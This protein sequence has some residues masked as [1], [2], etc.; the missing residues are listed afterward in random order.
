LRDSAAV[1]DTIAGPAPGDPYTAPAPRRPF[2]EEPGSNPGSL[3]IGLVT[4]SALGDVHGDCVEAAESAARLLEQLGHRVEP[5][6]VPA[7]DR[8]EVGPWIAAGIARD[9]DRWSER[10]GDPIGATDVEPLTWALAEVGRATNGAQYVAQAEA[11]WAWSRE[12][13]QPW[14][15]G[16]DLLL[17]P[18]SA[19]PPP[20]IGWVA[21]TVPFPE[22]LQRMGQQTIFTLPFDVTG[23]PALSLP[24]HWNAAGLP[25]GV[26]LVAATA[27]EDLLFRIGAQLEAAQPWADRRPP[28]HA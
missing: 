14:S 9:L 8:V 21:P 13:Q 1:L 24:L 3:R 6:R 17:T 12:L 10:T 23:Q 19:L 15:D 22:L 28:I 7:L 18:T 26:Q 2:A 27:R 11:A 5:A 16:L 4:S 20:R 25:I